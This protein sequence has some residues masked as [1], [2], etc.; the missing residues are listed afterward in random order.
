MTWITDLY[1]QKITYWGNPVSGGSGGYT[2]DS[3]TTFTGRWEEKQKV[4]VSPDGKEQVS[5]AI[6]YTPQDLDIGGYVYLGESTATD[7]QV[8]SDAHVIK[9]FNK[10]PSIDADEFARK[11]FV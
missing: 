6:I 2:F 4:F 5:A 9:G 10:V 11:V 1:N 8:V 3:P 7:P